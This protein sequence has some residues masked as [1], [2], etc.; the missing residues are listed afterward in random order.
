M[1][2]TVEIFDDIHESLAYQQYGD[3]RV[4]KGRLE[5][6]LE[7]VPKLLDLGLSP[8]QISDA[9]HLPLEAVLSIQREK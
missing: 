5:G 3:E 1:I 6:K 2:N 7:V 8:E 4:A 9:L